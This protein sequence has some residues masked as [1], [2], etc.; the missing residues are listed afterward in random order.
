MASREVLDELLADLAP[1]RLLD[2]GCGG[3]ARAGSIGVDVDVGVLRSVAAEGMRAVAGDALAL[4]VRW[5]A[6]DAAVACG[7][8][9]HLLDHRAALTELARAVRPGGSVIV[10]DVEPQRPD[11]FA[12]MT[13][14]LTRRGHPTEPGN[15]VALD[16]LGRAMTI[17]GLERQS[18][19]PVGTWQHSCPPWTDDVYTSRAWLYHAIRAG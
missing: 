14:E 3:G 18:A 8:V 11:R 13:D 7:L 6:V 17:A 15:G 16:D 10:L 2:V 12:A 1:A 9:H 4:P 5:L 19:R